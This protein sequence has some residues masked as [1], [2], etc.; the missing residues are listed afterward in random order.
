MILIAIVFVCYLLAREPR[1]TNEV[2]G[3]TTEYKAQLEESAKMQRL[4]TQQLETAREQQER[5]GKILDTWEAQQR[6]YQVYLDK[7][8]TAQH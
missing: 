3:Y 4:S 6:Q 5:F 1:Q 2:S 7:L 8:Q